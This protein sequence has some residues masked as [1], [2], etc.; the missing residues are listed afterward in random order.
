MNSIQ[1]PIAIRTTAAA[2]AVF[3]T[4]ATLNT[5][6]VEA[7]PHSALMAQTAARAAARAA[8]APLLVQLL[9]QAP[10]GEIELGH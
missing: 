1:T 2:L 3:M 10:I 7:G 9:A 4:V 8:S 5:L 6:F